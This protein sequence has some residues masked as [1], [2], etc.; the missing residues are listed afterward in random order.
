MFK[1]F[2][3][4]SYC[5]SIFMIRHVLNNDAPAERIPATGL[6]GSLRIKF[7]FHVNGIIF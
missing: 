3:L 2:Y 4:I 5:K 1:N 7:H 6:P